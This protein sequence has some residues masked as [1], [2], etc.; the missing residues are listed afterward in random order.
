M[1]SASEQITRYA[2]V[3]GPVGAVGSFVSDVLQ[4]LIPLCKWVFGLSLVIAIILFAALMIWRTF[5]QQLMPPF[6]LVMSFLVFSGILLA[7]QNQS[8][9]TANKGVLASHFSSIEDLQ[10]FLGVMQKEISDIKVATQ[11]IAKSTDRIATSLE[12]MQQSF[13]NLS[14]TGGI[15]ENAT[16]PEEHYHNARL[17]EMRGDY[18]NARRAYNSF[19]AFKLDLLD[20]H[21]RY[22][23]FLNVQEGRAGTREIYTGLY[24]QDKR[25]VVEFARILAFDAPQRTE[26]LK[27]FI[28]ANPD[29]APAYYELSREYSAARKGTQSLGDK[30]AELEALEQFQQ[31]NAEGK[32]LKYFVDKELAAKWIEDADTR[33]KS[34]SIL[35][36]SDDKPVDMTAMRSNSLWTITLQMKEIP[37]EVFYKLDSEAEFRSTGL[38]DETNPATG[39]KMPN[40]Y[41]Q[42][43]PSAS[44]SKIL[45][46]YADIG[47]EIRGPY[48][49][50]FDP[51]IE[52]FESGKKLLDMNKYN[53]I[54]F[55]DYDGRILVY[56]TPLLTGRC[57]LKE[58]AYGINSDATP[59]IFAMDKCNPADP[60]SIGEGNVYIEAP[61]STKYLTVQLTYKDG[62]KSAPQRFE[63]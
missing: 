40:M 16:R 22:Q 18:I 10:T 39:L 26:L 41:F 15:I 58:I 42:L 55:R 28:G 7:L 51:D 46:K 61:H 27:V 62:S 20:P 54:S 11:S 17:F 56:F 53:W 47:N 32:L 8:E 25:P 50:P 1:F 36:Q 60:Y 59:N 34:L 35:K 31:F 57:A 24:E 30:R 43:P 44:K 33:V 48:E 5:R 6:V 19:F 37:R 12:A 9:D 49:L 45:V 14:K 4:P 13:T 23:T 3:L 63:R 52:L 2:S 29:F 21:L 38:M